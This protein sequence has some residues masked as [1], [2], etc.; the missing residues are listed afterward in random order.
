MAQAHRRKPQPINGNKRRKSMLQ[1]L[2]VLGL[3][4]AG[5]YYFGRATIISPWLYIESATRF[6]SNRQGKLLL[7]LNV[8]DGVISFD[9]ANLAKGPIV[10]NNSHITT[11]N[12]VNRW[13]ERFV[14]A[15]SAASISVLFP[16]VIIDAS[17]RKAL[18]ALISKERVLFSVLAGGSFAGGFVL[19]R[20]FEL[21]LD[22]PEYR[23]ALQNTDLWRGVWSQKMKML[24]ARRSLQQV[25]ANLAVLS[26]KDKSRIETNLE[27]KQFGARRFL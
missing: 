7:Q 19:G 27:L 10:E 13:V 11:E 4:L 9:G 16:G 17:E 24:K 20:R 6:V 22:S 2:A 18:T 23:Q 14:N 1:F 26:Y 12:E 25:L 5:G 15:E 3:V 8:P 21:N